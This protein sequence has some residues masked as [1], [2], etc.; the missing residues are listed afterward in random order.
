MAIDGSGPCKIRMIFADRGV[1]LAPQQAILLDALLGRERLV[2]YAALADAL[3]GAHADGGPL[4]TESHIRAG[5][6]K[7]RRRIA[8]AGVPWRIENV[9][10]IGY[11]LRYH[12]A[13]PS[14]R[15]LAA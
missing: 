1:A 9:Y 11:R 5:V 8:T 10:G 12:E 7:L 13:A 3:W 4:D 2:S 15:L 14:E 6:S